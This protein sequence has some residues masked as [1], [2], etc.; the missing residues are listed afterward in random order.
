MENDFS[1]LERLMEFGMS[2][3]VA[4]Q[5]IATMN[6]SIGSMTVPGVNQPFCEQVEYYAVIDGKQAGPFTE[7]NLQQLA[8]K[9]TLASDTLMW[10]RGLSG[11]RRA[12]DIPVANK[13]L[14]L[15]K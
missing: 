2:M 4:Q 1:S 14:L 13:W 12:C 3:A 9:G 8:Q 7:E 15:S 10:H 6:H 5:M 11:W